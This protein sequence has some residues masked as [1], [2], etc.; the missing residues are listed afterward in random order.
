M[1]AALQSWQRPKG[2][3][4]IILGHRGVRGPGVSVTENTLGAFEMAIDAGADGVELDVRLAKD[5]AVVVVHDATLKRIT[6]GAHT[7]RVDALGLAEL[8][9]VT[10]PGAQRISTLDEVLAW[11][12]R[13]RCR[14]NVELKHEGHDPTRLVAGVADIV[15]AHSRLHTTSP[16]RLL[17]SS[18]DKATVL[19]LAARLEGYVVAWLTE[20]PLDMG[21]EAE[22]LGERG[23]VA[24]HPKHSLL[25]AAM[26]AALR[27]RFA[28][29][30][31]WT[32]NDPIR[33]AELARL[34]VDCVISDDPAGARRALT[35]SA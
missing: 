29:V 6:L 9:A 22:V 34:G 1:L 35:E 13:H 28:V 33:V 12:G 8:R 18:F 5:G 20:R 7:A 15:D 4:P 27:Q 19:A 16:D 24:I 17:F 11:A 30:N 2:E 21:A 31:T 14:V 25:N 10:L 3:R 32:V 26:L 23:V